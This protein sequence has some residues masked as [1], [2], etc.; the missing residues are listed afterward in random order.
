MRELRTYRGDGRQ[1]R[2]RSVSALSL[3]S[4]RFPSSSVPE[5]VRNDRSNNKR[6]GRALS[7]TSMQ[8]DLSIEGGQS[9][10]QRSPT[11][12]ESAMS[13]SNNHILNALPQPARLPH[14]IESEKSP[15]R[16]R[17]FL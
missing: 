9:R 6:C 5:A 14:F 2:Y 12:Q 3:V 17:A 15:R 16:P 4:T 8:S 10:D 1:N 11:R 13:Q 7:K